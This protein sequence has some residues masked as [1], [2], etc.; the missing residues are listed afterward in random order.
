MTEETVD[1]TPQITKTD[2]RDLKSLVRND[3][4]MLQSE[5]SRRAGRLD[6]EI[7]AIRQERHEEDEAAAAKE[8]AGLTRR[9]NSLNA[10]IVAKISELA[11]AGW[12]SRPGGYYGRSDEISPHA[13]TVKFQFGNLTPPSRDNSDIEE[14]SSQVRE[15]AHDAKLGLDRA[16]ADFIRELTL[17]SVTSE[18]ARVFITAL[19]TPESLLPQPALTA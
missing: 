3:Y 7:N 2:A 16:E 5:L 15:Q 19:P 12:T 18:S 14:A 13:F 17:Q 1:V 4:K 9:V 11:E 8:L 10:A 6:E